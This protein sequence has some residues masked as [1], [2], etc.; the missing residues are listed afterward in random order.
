MMEITMELR[1]I[2]YL[3]AVA[4]YGNISKAAE[5]LYISQ[6][7]LSK[8]ISGLEKRINLPLFNRIGKR[9][10]L[11]YAG[12]RYFA[13][14]KEIAASRDSL[15]SELQDIAGSND[16]E[17]K[18]AVPVIRGSHILPSVIP[19]FRKLYPHV[20]L[21]LNEIESQPLENLLLDGDIDLAIIHLP[22]K[23]PAIRSTLI[24]KEC[25]LMAVPRN[26]P[27]IKYGKDLP[28]YSFQ[29]IDLTLFRDE[30]FILTK[31]NQRT[32]QIC[33][34]LF[35]K[36]KISPHIILCTANIETAVRLSAAEVGISFAPETFIRFL[37]RAS[38][39]QYFIIGDPIV[40]SDLV[41]AYRNGM[42]L[43]AYAKA[44][45]EI[46]RKIFSQKMI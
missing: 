6:P 15:E 36:E 34:E 20:R 37:D 10:V 19:E 7:A 29:W 4:K 23:N 41:I 12:E 35:K 46:T 11:T 31:P 40:T 30:G 27:L 5:S 3:I 26:N 2:D 9:L 8:Y 13:R 24:R 28:G 17:L 1:D 43:S 39:A 45:I 44:F 32:R 21:T 14:A 22:I 42:Y 18:I 33:D 38:T 25:L 16:G